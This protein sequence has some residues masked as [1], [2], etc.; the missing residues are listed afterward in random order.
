MTMILQK[1]K[2]SPKIFEEEKITKI[3]KIKAKKKEEPALKLD[4]REEPLILDQVHEEKKV[5]FKKRKNKFSP[6][7]RKMA[8]E[9]KS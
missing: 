3:K 9:D 7:A 1:K 8:S 2:I 4:D 5:N 6:A